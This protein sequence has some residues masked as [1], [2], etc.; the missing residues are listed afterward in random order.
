MGIH[1]LFQ[2]LESKAPNSYRE[3]GIDVFTS[4]KLAIDASKVIL[5]DNLPISR[6]DNKLRT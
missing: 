4:K 3:I 5:S 1:K 6:F 2:L